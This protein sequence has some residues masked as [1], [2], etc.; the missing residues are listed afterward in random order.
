[1]SSL[2][3]SSLRP[4]VAALLLCAMCCAGLLP[5]PA[6]A[7]DELLVG[8]GKYR[9]ARGKVGPLPSPQPGPIV[10]PDGISLL[11][12]GRQT[13]VR[14]DKISPDLY[15]LMSG[16]SLSRSAFRVVCQFNKTPGAAVNAIYQRPNVSVNY[17]LQNLNYAVATM[18]ASVIGELAALKEVSFI[19][20]DREV[21]TLGHVSATTGADLVRNQVVPAP[22]ALRTRRL[23]ML[24]LGARP[25][26]CAFEM[27]PLPAASEAT[28]VPCPNAS[29]VELSLEPL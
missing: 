20:P 13:V 9:P 23:M 15:A 4:Y 16:R 27:R 6:R 29:P 10:S 18:P 22:C 24:A 2:K 14:P 11:K 28:C 17:S 1:M 5:L 26:Y 25:A 19:S 7:Q 8:R 21:R 12:N 3:L